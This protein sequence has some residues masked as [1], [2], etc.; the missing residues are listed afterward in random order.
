MNQ[1]SLNNTE[2][3]NNTAQPVQP[4]YSA[5]VQPAQPT[6]AAPAQPAQPTP[7]APVQPAQPTPAAPVQPAQPTYAAPVQP[8]QPTY[9]APV[10]PVQ[11]APA[12]PVEPAQPTYAAPVQPEPMPV[13]IEEAQSVEKVS[14]LN[15]EDAMEEALSHTNQYTPFEVQQEE[16]NQ[17]VS[18]MSNKKALIFLGVIFAIMV[19]FII[20]LPQ[21]SDLIGW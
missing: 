14:N 3:V 18:F 19:L 4:T 15:K 1:E 20:F 13:N 16:V 2:N 11:P 17:E 12:A 21:I 9:A 7:A 8:A 10:Q 6:Y 5:P